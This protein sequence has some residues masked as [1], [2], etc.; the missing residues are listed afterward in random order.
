MKSE[1]CLSLSLALTLAACASEPGVS[2]DGAMTDHAEHQSADHSGHD[3]SVSKEEAAKKQSISDSL[4]DRFDAEQCADAEALATM[5]KTEPDGRATVLRA[6]QAPKACVEE[7]NA[8]FD[9]LGF[10]QT[11]PGIYA[12][13]STEGTTERLLIEMAKDGSGT[14]VEWEIEKR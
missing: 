13:G 1:I 7:L 3:M 5:R 2:D 10:T 12:G 8:A 11:E 9:T 4:A 6:F 14:L